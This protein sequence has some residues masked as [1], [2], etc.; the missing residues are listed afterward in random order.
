VFRDIAIYLRRLYKADM[1]C[2]DLMNRIFIVLSANIVHF[3]CLPLRGTNLGIRHDPIHFRFLVG[4][5]MDILLRRDPRYCSLVTLPL[6]IHLFSFKYLPHLIMFK[7]LF[8]FNYF[9]HFFMI[10]NNRLM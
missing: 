1:F 3:S 5:L 4:M 9:T 6:E 7:K 10:K 8:L 2:E